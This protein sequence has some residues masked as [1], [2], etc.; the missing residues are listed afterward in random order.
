M[1][2]GAT[3]LGLFG[4][5]AGA[6]FGYVFLRLGSTFFQRVAEG[7]P[8]PYMTYKRPILSLIFHLAELSQMAAIIPL[9]LAAVGATLF[10]CQREKIKSRIP[11]L[12]LW[13]PSLINISALYWGLIY[14]L[15][16]SVLLLPAVAIFASLGI[17]SDIVKKR[18]LIFLLLGILLLP[19]I[20]WVSVKVGSDPIFVPGP[21]ALILPVVGLILFFVVQIRPRH[22][23]PL[24][25]LCILSMQFPPLAREDRPMMTE[26]LEHEFIEPERQEILQYLAQNYDHKRI[27]IDMGRQ[28][29]LIYDSGLAVKE[30][31]YNE[32]GGVFWHKAISN[33][34][35]QVGW[36]F[37]EKG[38]AVWQRILAD[39]RIEDAYALAVKTDHFYLY[40]LK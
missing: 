23:W 20:H 1:A 3:F 36:I 39:S 13:I 5:L 6:H 33:P 14:R 32:G 29:P 7:N 34:K 10:F 2:A 11:L 18:S 30:F 8:N 19:W 38:D 9:L 22:V 26:T 24:L 15:R 37:A 16:Y 27:L 4:A 28:A 31:V 21:G 12:L 25:L 40:R 35:Q 17:P